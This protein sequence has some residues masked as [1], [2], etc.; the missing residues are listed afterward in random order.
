MLSKSAVTL[1]CGHIQRS[2]LSVWEENF[3]IMAE[4]RRNM[5]RLCQYIYK[6]SIELAVLVQCP[7]LPLLQHGTTVHNAIRKTLILLFINP[8]RQ[9][10]KQNNC[11]YVREER[12]DHH[13][14]CGQI[15]NSVI[16]LFFFT[17]THALSHTNMYKCF[18]LY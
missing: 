3:L 14:N 18:K 8:E 12:H 17:P 2:A 11:V 16:H 10:I 9:A 15:W 5:L 1:I 4:F 6:C 13:H 7:W